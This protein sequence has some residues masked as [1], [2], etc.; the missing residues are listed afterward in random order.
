[1]ATPPGL[2]RHPLYASLRA[3]KYQ[4]AL[5]DSTHHTKGIEMSTTFAARHDSTPAGHVHFNHLHLRARLMQSVSGT[6]SAAGFLAQAGVPLFQALRI[7]G[8]PARLSL[9]VL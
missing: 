2:L 3:V 6:G 7:L 4:S 9:G 5:N 8:I 1:M